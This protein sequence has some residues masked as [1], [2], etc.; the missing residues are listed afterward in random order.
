[1]SNIT[2]YIKVRVYLYKYTPPFS[3][4]SSDKNIDAKKLQ[5]I[6]DS[7]A[8]LQKQLDALKAQVD[9]TQL[10]SM[11]NQAVLDQADILLQWNHVIDPYINT[12][13]PA[14]WYNTGGWSPYYSQVNSTAYRILNELATNRVPAVEVPTTQALGFLVA[15]KLDQVVVYYIQKEAG[16]FDNM[17][18]LYTELLA[19]SKREILTIGNEYDKTLSQNRA[20]MY[21]LAANFI[22]GT[23]KLTLVKSVQTAVGKEAALQAQIDELSAQESAALGGLNKVQRFSIPLDE[24]YLNKID[25]S[26]FVTN[27]DFTHSLNGGMS[28]NISFNNGVIEEGDLNNYFKQKAPGNLSYIVS[29]YQTE[30]DGFTNEYDVNQ[31]IIDRAI[32]YRSKSVTK[33]LTEQ[34]TP[35]EL[36]QD[37]ELRKPVILLSDLIQKYDYISCYIYKSPEPL[38]E[39]LDKIKQ[40]YQTWFPGSSLN[41]DQ[42]SVLTQSLGFSNEF[43]GF[44]TSSNF[45]TSVGSMNTLNI[46]GIGSFGL[47]DR[48]KVLYSP[49]LFTTSIYDQV[50]MFDRNQ[51]S[52]FSSIFSDKSVI[53]I[54]DILLRDVYRI[55]SLPGYAIKSFEVYNKGLIDSA[56]ANDKLKLD[57]YKKTLESTAVNLNKIEA[58]EVDGAITLYNSA[59]QNKNSVDSAKSAVNRLEFQI[60]TQ[61]DN[62]NSMVTYGNV[63]SRNFTILKGVGEKA[64]AQLQETL[65]SI[66]SF[67][68]FDI[69]RLKTENK[70]QT[71]LFTIAPFL[72]S[73]VMNK[74]GYMTRNDD[75]SFVDATASTILQMNMSLGAGIDKFFSDYSK[76]PSSY[77]SPINLEVDVNEFKPYFLFLENGYANFEPSV[78]T[79]NEI[80][81]EIKTTTFIEMFETSS[82]SF[83]IRTPRYNDTSTTLFSDNY[84]II[85]TSYSDKATGL[86]T[87]E[88]LSYHPDLIKN[89]PFN[90]FSFVN[91]KLLLQYGLNE[92]NVSAN[93]NVKFTLSSNADVDAN[94][95]AGIFNYCRF[96]LEL[97]N[98]AQKTCSISMEYIPAFQ[99]VSNEA[100][101][102]KAQIFQPGNLF[103]DSRNSKISYITSVQKR[104]VVGG[105]LTMTVEGNYTRD[106]IR[107]GDEISFRK[108]PELKEL[109]AQ[110]GTAQ[111]F[112]T[113]LNNSIISNITSNPTVSTSSTVVVN[114]PNTK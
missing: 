18:Y 23:Y 89:I 99:Y 91:G 87:K 95:A 61:Q 29:A 58:V 69:S 74:K 90:I 105:A 108:L 25:I 12:W 33:N 93:P 15:Q 65:K 39:R 3:Q 67:Y 8:A 98:A 73:S 16:N 43:N 112:E 59:A 21:K 55:G 28:W 47:F 113:N 41:L 17:K 85:S 114:V 97:N 66:D 106:A 4:V 81:D 2:E 77:F 36:I 92:T 9:P 42:E 19:L 30:D 48:T 79:P 35:E 37:D 52:A 75:Q 88:K 107:V 57:A 68:F 6:K 86:I 5:A 11:Q 78:K 96:Y 53:E 63:Y 24:Q 20:N 56:Q 38:D 34:A 109:N 22:N 80:L 100:G 102:A 110:F 13:S 31:S 62:M 82:G 44:V 46:S 104:C 94:K 76:Q 70:L 54:V 40:D 51:M 26:N 72:Y 14:G 27:Y 7:K 49:T 1:M 64:F 111:Q 84:S 10:N 83:N 101:F 50:E 45:N 103:F 32:Q 71:N 60:K